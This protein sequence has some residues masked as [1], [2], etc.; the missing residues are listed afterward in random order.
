MDKK[1]C[2]LF[3]NAASG[4]GAQKVTIR[5][6]LTPTLL[7]PLVGFPRKVG[8][9]EPELQ[10]QSGS[11]PPACPSGW[12]DGTWLPPPRLYQQ[13]K[14]RGGSVLAGEEPPTHSAELN[15]VLSQAG[16]PTQSQLSR[17]TSSRHHISM[18]DRP[19]R[20][21]LL[22]NHDTNARNETFLKETPEKRKRRN[23]SSKKKQKE[24]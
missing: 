14:H 12:C 20:K 11:E 23:I 19:R 17:P 16:G 6:S 24:K 1:G 13:Q 7:D 10:A 15:H 3:K 8:S 5:N 2:G 21:H 18:E 4:A 9:H 22:L